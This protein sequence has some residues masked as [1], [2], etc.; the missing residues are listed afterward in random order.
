VNTKKKD[1]LDYFKELPNI[2]SFDL[3]KFKQYLGAEDEAFVNLFKKLIGDLKNSN[4]KLLESEHRLKS[5]TGTFDG[6]IWDVDL[7]GVY[8][9]LSEGVYELTGYKPEQLI[10]KS[11]FNLVP[12]SEEKKLYDFYK[13][14]IKKKE[15][16]INFENV[17]LKKDGS[18]VFVETS[19]LPI[20]DSEGNL[21]GY[22]G[23]DI[24]INSRKV[25]DLLSSIQTDILKILNEPSFDIYTSVK[26]IVKIIKNKLDISAVGFRL[27]KD[28][29]FPYIYQDGFSSSFIK[30]ENSLLI[31]DEKLGICKNQDGSSSLECTCGLVI[32]GKFDHNN[33][34]FTKNG[35]AWT[36]DSEPFLHVPSEND[37]RT[38]PRNKCIH[39]GYSSIA[40]IP[41]KFSNDKIVGLLQL[42][43]KNKGRFSLQMV[44]FFEDLSLS[45]GAGLIR[46]KLEKE[47]SDN[48]VFIRS[49]LDNLSIGVAVNNVFP[50]VELKYVNDNFAKIYRLKKEDLLNKDPDTFWELVYEDEPFRK[51][52]KERVLKDCASG[53]QSRMIWEEIPISR[54]G[55]ET[56]YVSA[57]N[58]PI[59]DQGFFISTVWDVTD[60]VKAE[61]DKAK[62]LALE[63]QSKTL[64]IKEKVLSMT[65]HDL[66]SPL[67]IIRRAML[68]LLD[69]PRLNKEI[70]KHSEIALRQSVRG[71]KFI[72]DFFNLRKFRDGIIQLEKSEFKIS[73]ILKGIKEDNQMFLE[74]GELL[75]NFNLEKDYLIFADYSKM[76]Q[77]FNNLIENAIKHTPKKGVIDIDF[78]LK[79]SVLK[80]LVRDTGE[81]IPTENIPTLFNYY[82]QVRS[83]DELM[84]TGMG[85]P[86]AKYIVELHGGKIWL[87]SIL[88]KGTSF[89]FTIPNAR[90]CKKSSSIKNGEKKQKKLKNKKILNGKQEAKTI[91]I[92]DDAPEDRLVTRLLLEKKGFNVYE[93]DYWKEALKKIRTKKIDALILDVHMP[94]MTGFE[95][96]E[97]IRREKT[98]EELPVIFYS[99][100][101][102]D[103][104]SYKKYGA[105]LY[106]NKSDL[107]DKLLSVIKKIFN[108]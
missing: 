23:I 13:D 66:K 4:K 63:L 100:K 103:K 52:I 105:D 1:F 72:N 29:D 81:G 27:E 22:R 31:K 80:V 8:T 59:P 93:S 12:K 108:S 50:R 99:S 44:E 34:L 79:G 91:L 46:K 106:V 49:T 76:E 43:D 92:V 48:E 40:L 56:F 39:D 96:L 62:L 41:I 84:G 95:L 85:L 70:K 30:T 65:S 51:E 20:L 15:K 88:G 61:K 18:K 17:I 101:N 47:L 107:N 53:D 77:V 78:K 37:P 97:I 33:P 86:I 90:P 102:L 94:D 71:L 5:V 3:E 9:Y 104:K 87:E 24:N 32:S 73:K 69:R 19:G 74:R 25:M 11:I 54:K 16:I 67:T 35:S 98:K 42:N 82:E 60:R 36:N 38:N 21:I 2:E 75:L 55:Q 28:D 83:P 89:F 26:N 6:F 7:E 45:I 10:G 57:A 14:L 64:E 58:I 68:L